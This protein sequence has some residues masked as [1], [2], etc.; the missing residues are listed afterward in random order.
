MG[1]V[2]PFRGRVTPEVLQHSIEWEEMTEV[3]IVYK[4]YDGK[5]YL[6]TSDITP[7]KALELLDKARQIL[8]ECCDA[9][10]QH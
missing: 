7:T 1:D 2:I 9:T 3:I 4:C 5:K 10:T 8:I 6:D